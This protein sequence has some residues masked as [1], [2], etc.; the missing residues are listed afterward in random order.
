MA[1]ETAET[2]MASLGIGPRWCCQSQ[3]R[4]GRTSILWKFASEVGEYIKQ[5][6]ADLAEEEA[7]LRRRCAEMRLLPE[8]ERKRYGS[9]NNCEWIVDPAFFMGKGSEATI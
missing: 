8:R 3:A 9:S 4:C 1:M 6:N 7:F 5:A 2:A